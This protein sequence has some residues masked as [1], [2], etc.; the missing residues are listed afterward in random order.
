MDA[1]RIERDPDRSLP[2]PTRD[3]LE[4]LR[5]LALPA[6][7][8]VLV[9]CDAADAV[10]D[11]LR[12]AGLEPATAPDLATLDL[13]ARS[14]DAA[15]IA[16][17]LERT[18][19]DRWALQQVHRL[20]VP[21][22]PLVLAVPNLAA[23]ATLAEPAFAAGLV[24]KRLTGLLRR[25][26]RKPPPPPPPFTRRKYR[27]RALVHVLERLGYRVTDVRAAGS[28]SPEPLGLKP[29]HAFVPGWT[30]VAR[31]EGSLYGG[32]GGRPWPDPAAFRA[33]FEREHHAFLAARDRWVR[34]HAARAADPPVAL[35]PAAHAGARVLVLAP[36][37]DD[38]VLGCGGTLAKL[39]AAGARVT[40]VHATDGS[41][42]TSLRRAPEPQRRTARLDE[43]QEVGAAMGF[44][45]LE[46][47]R[48]DNAAFRESPELADRLS[49]T[50]A[51]LDPALVF[52][53]F[54]TDIHP[55]HR[56]LARLLARALR[57]L[58]RPSRAE[59][60]SYQVWCLVPPNRY[61]DVTEVAPTL[62]E[63]LLRYVTAM[64]V[65]DYIHIA[66]DR[67]YYNACIL[68]GRPG[69]AEAFRATGAV[70]YPEL[71]ATME[72]DRG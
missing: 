49:Q 36:H 27:I 62:E 68:T 69:Y 39:I 60:M 67:N 24:R 72:G 58:A 5:R 33:R 30:L 45:S 41:E 28:R 48:Q 6:R 22:A 2:R 12:R 59:I 63:A 25:A 15:V 34:A 3:A 61:C 37:P 9:A 54:V 18:E 53:P 44:S 13:P 31:T 70:A 8:R 43:A 20:L 23:P 64:K 38:E 21:G 52:V 10:R 19:W 32:A 7:S 56:V 14:F 4:Q 35:D 17:P 71:A 65:E 26:L 11:I 1:A 55:D 42:A 46:L 16:G 66:Q 51:E 47:W 57:S 29:G 50:L 40:V